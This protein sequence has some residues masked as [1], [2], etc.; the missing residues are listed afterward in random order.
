MLENINVILASASPRR[1]ELLAQAGM[2][3][4]IIVSDCEEH[5]MA[6]APEEYV[7]EL[8]GI[9]AEDEE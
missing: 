6:H 9:K 8:A 4:K 3:H 5:A 7:V 2:N 1:T